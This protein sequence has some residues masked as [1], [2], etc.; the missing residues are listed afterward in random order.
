M[1]LRVKTDYTYKEERVVVANNLI[2]SR[3]PGTAFEF[4]LALVKVLMGKEKREEIEGPMI[5]PPGIVGGGESSPDQV[6]P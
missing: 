6:Q 2:T 5:L 4:A 3:G 1:I